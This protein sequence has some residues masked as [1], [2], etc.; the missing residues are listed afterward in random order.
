[1]LKS[2]IR[3]RTKPLR[4]AKRVAS[5]YF[6]REKVMAITILIKRKVREQT[7]SGLDF[8]LRRM[9]SLTVKQPGYISGETF[10]RIDEDGESLVISNWQTLDAW[11]KWRETAERIDL[12]N[13]IDLLIGEPTQYEIYEHV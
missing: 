12:Q 3:G 2:T 7:A 10:K 6:D 9:R 13:E 5:A 1:M 8:L 4:L 11:R